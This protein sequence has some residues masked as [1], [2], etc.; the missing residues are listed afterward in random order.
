[1]LRLGSLPPMSAF[2]H[3]HYVVLEWRSEFCHQLLQLLT[4]CIANIK[5]SLR[6]VSVRSQVRP[7]C[8][9]GSRKGCILAHNVVVQSWH[10]S[11]SS[12]FPQVLFSFFP[13]SFAPA[14][15]VVAP[16]QCSVPLHAWS[17][18]H[19][20]GILRFAFVS[21]IFTSV[22]HTVLHHVPSSW[23]LS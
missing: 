1:M 9:R 22:Q 3:R 11:I 19:V 13:G 14:L 18:W 15:N 8:E 21:G 6:E 17:S 4:R 10:S 2:C 7:R 5:C 20:V 12:N 23:Q 16:V